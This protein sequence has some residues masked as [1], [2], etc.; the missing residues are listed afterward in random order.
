[1]KFYERFNI[2]KYSKK[3]DPHFPRIIRLKNE[4]GQAWAWWY[5]A[6]IPTLLRLRQQDQKFKAR[7][8]QKGK[9]GI[10]TESKEGK[11]K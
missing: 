11:G 1:M 10:G 2:I 4:V 3:L 9:G 7:L 5:T 6:V 8:G